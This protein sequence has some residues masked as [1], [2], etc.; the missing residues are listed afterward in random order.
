MHSQVA[1]VHRTH[2]GIFLLVVALAFF[3]APGH[4]RERSRPATAQL[5]EAETE[6]DASDFPSTI[7]TC[8]QI[9]A[10]DPDNPRA[11]LLRGWSLTRLHKFDAALVDLNDLLALSPGSGYY[12]QQRGHTLASADRWQD[13]LDDYR[14][15]VEANPRDPIHYVNTAYVLDHLGDL[16]AALED[17]DTAIRI[18]PQVA[19]THE[20]RG[21]I[22][23]RHDRLREAL[24]DFENCA[25]LTT[26]PIAYVH[27][28][29]WLVRQRLGEKDAA[30]RELRTIFQPIE[31]TRDNI[32]LTALAAYALGEVP[33]NA[34][35]EIAT[36]AHPGQD[37]A[38][39]CEAF[40]FIG[41]KK[42]LAGDWDAAAEYFHQCLATGQSHWQEYGFA[43][44]ELATFAPEH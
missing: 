10:G 27:L 42:R 5:D 9:L 28:H 30:D 19:R 36:H 1:F 38:H 32:W 21:I 39:L 16:T 17:S 2:A 44:C 23:F 33:D 13:A 40:Y 34:L 18:G 4:S 20:C 37:R 41:E 3:A 22:Y 6:Y 14:A 24:A 12:L 8:T 35:I 43:A 15:A 26:A 29:L 25:A 31:P 7:Q 11:L